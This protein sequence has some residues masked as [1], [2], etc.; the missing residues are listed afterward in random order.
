MIN[1]SCILF[2]STCCEYINIVVTCRYHVSNAGC[3]QLSIYAE[4]RTERLNLNFV[5][6]L[7]FAQWYAVFSFADSL[8]ALSGKKIEKKIR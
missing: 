6:S 1:V 4:L 3:T 5:V 2:V 8:L 7:H